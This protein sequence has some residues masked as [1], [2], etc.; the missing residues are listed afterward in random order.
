MIGLMKDAFQPHQQP[1]QPQQPA[2]VD[3]K[4]VEK[5]WKLMDKVPVTLCNTSIIHNVIVFC[6]HYFKTRISDVL[7]SDASATYIYKE[8]LTTTLFINPLDYI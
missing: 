2:V 5:C 6:D 1:P 7:I 3:R 8:F 4:M